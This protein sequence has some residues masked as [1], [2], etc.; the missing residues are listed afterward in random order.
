MIQNVLHI[1]LHFSSSVF[2][3]S[4]PLVCVKLSRN[5]LF[6][7]FWNKR[8]KGMKIDKLKTT[9]NFYP[10]QISCE[11][12]LIEIWYRRN[13]VIQF[14]LNLEGIWSTL[15]CKW[16]K[17]RWHRKDRFKFKTTTTTTNTTTSLHK[18]IIE[19]ENGLVYFW[20]EE[21]P[22]LFVWSRLMYFWQG[23]KVWQKRKK[24][25]PDS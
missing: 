11:W 23:W 7:I 14:S 18:L 16:S 2:I 8:W 5:R 25:K 1:Y 19:G 6:V 20:R 24:K 22:L 10:R 3:L 15:N 9:T 21:T 13:Y 12:I 4:V 17:E